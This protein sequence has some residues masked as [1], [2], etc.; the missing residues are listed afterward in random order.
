MVF[1]EAVLYAKTSFTELTFK[2]EVH[3]FAAKGAFH[4]DLSP[5]F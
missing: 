5:L 4:Q 1:G 2:G 3:L